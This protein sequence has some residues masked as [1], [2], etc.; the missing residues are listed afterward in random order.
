MDTN[1]LKATLLQ[2]HRDLESGGKLDPELQQLLKTLDQDIQAT[3]AKSDAAAGMEATLSERAQVID[4]RFS[5]E[6]PY[7]SSTLR[8]LMDTL[9]KMGI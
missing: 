4:A 6:H 2:L 5:T 9:G 3:L 7:L 1:N 8:D